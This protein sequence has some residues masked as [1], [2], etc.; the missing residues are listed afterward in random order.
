MS[1]WGLTYEKALKN[2]AHYIAI[3]EN[4]IYLQDEPF[5][6]IA[7]SDIEEG[8]GR[9]FNGPTGFYVIA[10]VEGLKFK[11][12]VDFEGRDANGRGVSV[13]D[14]GRLRDVAGMLPPRVRKKLA[15]FLI[16]RVIPDLAKRTEEIRAALNQQADSEDCVRG[17]VAYCNDAL[18]S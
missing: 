4:E 17:L 9:R 12:N 10:V 7:A 18:S 15:E 11:W 1:F 13:F 6:W 3:G 8:S 2:A 14:R 5:P 16:A